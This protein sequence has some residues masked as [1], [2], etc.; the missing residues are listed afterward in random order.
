LA[1]LQTISPETADDFAAEG[2]HDCES[3][4][5]AS[6]AAV[7]KLSSETCSHLQRLRDDPLEDQDV[8]TAAARRVE[9]SEG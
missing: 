2:L 7:S 3:S 1:A 6:S 8:R 4:V 5:R 9:T